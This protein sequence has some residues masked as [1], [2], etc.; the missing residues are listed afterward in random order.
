MVLWVLGALLLGATV[1]AAMYAGYTLSGWEQGAVS[2]RQ[3]RFAVVGAALLTMAM[4][5]LIMGGM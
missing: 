5:A 3:A 2:K 4:L 1:W